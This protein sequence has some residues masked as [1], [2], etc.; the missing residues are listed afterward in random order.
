[1]AYV[2]LNEVILMEIKQ[3]YLKIKSFLFYAEISILVDHRVCALEKLSLSRT[4]EGCLKGNLL[5]NFFLRFL[6][7]PCFSPII[8]Q[9]YLLNISNR[10]LLPF[11]L[12]SAKKQSLKAFFSKHA[13]PVCHKKNYSPDL[14]QISSAYLYIIYLFH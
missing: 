2:C 3:I 6:F 1:M 13:F 14:H 11:S 7:L 10:Y 9:E 8:L 5:P 12:Y 4:A